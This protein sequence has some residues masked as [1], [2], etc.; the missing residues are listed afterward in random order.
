MALVLQFCFDQTNATI[1][2]LCIQVVF[3]DNFETNLKPAHEMGMVTIFVHD[4]DAAL[5]E[6]EKVTGVQV[7]F[8][9]CRVRFPVTCLCSAMLSKTHRVPGEDL[10]GG[11]LLPFL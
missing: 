11:R 3:L 9:L 7:T 1:H 5:K 8:Q 6:L 10:L 2:A 4:T